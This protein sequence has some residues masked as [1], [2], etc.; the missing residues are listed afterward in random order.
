MSA[1]DLAAWYLRLNGFLTVRNFLCQTEDSVRR[2]DIDI[3]GVRFPH[4]AEMKSLGVDMRDDPLFQSAPPVLD[5]VLAEVKRGLCNVNRSLRLPE[6]RNIEYVLEATGIF[7]SGRQRA[8]ARAL[9]DETEYTDRSRRV[10]ILAFGEFRNPELE[11]VRQVQW[12]E[13]IAFIHRRFTDRGPLPID[14]VGW[15]AYGRFL[16]QAANRRRASLAEFADEVMGSLGN[17]APKGQQPTDI[18][19]P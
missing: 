7:P 18:V 19:A 6:R 5:V 16:H 12:P 15:D 9:Y 2:T 11:K 13:V 8:V 14:D 4:R 1:E 3:V 10:R 17:G